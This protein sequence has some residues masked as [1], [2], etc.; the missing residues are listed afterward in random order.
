MKTLVVYYG[1]SFYKYENL[2]NDYIYELVESTL[3]KIYSLDPHSGQ[4]TL[5]ACFN[6][7]DYF[8]IQD[9]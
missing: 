9:D 8:L 7:W 4:E 2:F 5:I 1:D 6:K 3:L